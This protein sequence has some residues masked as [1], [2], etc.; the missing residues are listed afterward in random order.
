VDTLL[1]Q[2]R[3]SQ[4]ATAHGNEVTRLQKAALRE[5]L[6]TL[7][8]QLDRAL[9]A[10]YGIVAEDDPDG[11]AD[12]F[13]AWKASHQPFHWY[14]EFYGIMQRGGFDAIIGNP[15]YIVYAA[16]KV[17]Y[18]VTPQRYTTLPI[19]NLYALVFERSLE[20]AHPCS[21]IGLI[22]QLTV[23]SSERLYLLQDLLRARGLL[24]VIPFPRRPESIFDGV[25][26][27]VAIL[28]SGPGNIG[29]FVTS[30]VNRFYTEERVEALRNLVPVRHTIR[31]D[32]SRIAKI[33]MGQESCIARKVLD[34]S[35]QLESLIRNHSR[36]VMY[37]QEACRYWVKAHN[38][39]PFFRRNGEN[40]SPPHGRVLYFQDEIS[41]AFGTCIANSSLFYW[42]YSAF[43]D[44]EHINDSLMR[45]FRIPSDWRTTEWVPLAD[46]LS[47]S[48][49]KHAKRKTILTK[50]G[51]C[52]RSRSL[53]RLTACWRSITTSRTRNWTSSS[54][55]TSSTAWGRVRRRMRNDAR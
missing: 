22:V 10:E 6:D 32:S 35:S 30:R 50:Q 18:D 46:A 55:T 52:T 28:L 47:T 42:F 44:C 49:A 4:T 41:A 19:K 37:Y 40:I 23:A 3:E 2:F 9:A 33:G 39:L 53:M 27:P 54:T 13:A 38:G 31:I 43:S 36:S 11:Y 25:E 8:A 20:L 24:Q 29:D 5:Q 12:R 51:Q 1:T 14:S 45:G 15:P 7:A 16:A 17:D 34:C 26:M 48:L 21:P